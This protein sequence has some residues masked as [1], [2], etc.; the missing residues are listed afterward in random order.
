VKAARFLDG[1]SNSLEEGLGGFVAEEWGD[2]V[3]GWEVA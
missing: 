3:D 2:D 1:E